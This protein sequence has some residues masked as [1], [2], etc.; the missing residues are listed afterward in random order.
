MVEIIVSKTLFM[1]SKLTR[2]HKNVSKRLQFSLSNYVRLDY[3]KPLANYAVGK[4][5]CFL[6][7][8]SDGKRLLLEA[9]HPSY[10]KSKEDYVSTIVRAVAQYFS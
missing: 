5:A 3:S 4:D 8:F 7:S 1:R 6:R 9:Y 10:P 2:L